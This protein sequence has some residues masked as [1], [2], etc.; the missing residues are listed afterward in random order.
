MF[1]LL[2]SI[3]FTGQWLVFFFIIVLWAQYAVGILIFFRRAIW[4]HIRYAIW[5]A[6]SPSWN[7][8]P[9]R[10]LCVR[11]SLPA[12]LS[13]DTTQTHILRKSP[14]GTQNFE[15][16]RINYEKPIRLKHT[17]SSSLPLRSLR[18]CTFSK[19]LRMLFLSILDRRCE[20]VFSY[21][22]FNV[23]TI[24]NGMSTTLSQSLS[25]QLGYMLSSFS[26]NAC[27]LRGCDLT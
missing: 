6:L 9:V 25:K 11:F 14:Y 13:D 20:H 12:C 15:F 5:L 8:F 27:V 23:A 3:F 19:V 7:Y 2:D 4:V 17:F 10:F 16:Q 18:S 24:A 22:S 21:S 26:S 1:S